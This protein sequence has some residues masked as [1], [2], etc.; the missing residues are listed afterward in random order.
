MQQCPKCG[1]GVPDGRTTCHICFA[2]LG[3]DAQVE[4][5]AGLNFATPQ[6]AAVT[7][8]PAAPAGPLAGAPASIPV[9]PPP[10]RAAGIPGIPNPPQQPAAQSIPGLPGVYAPQEDVSAAQPNYLR[11]DASAMAPPSGM[12]GGQV[13]VSLTG[14]VIESAPA[15]PTISRMTGVSAA[16]PPRPGGPPVPARPTAPARPVRATES[17]ESKSGGSAA[18][19]II[20]IVVFLGAGGFGGWY[21]Y[22]NRTNPKD[23]AIKAMT[24]LK[25]MDWA[26]LHPLMAFSDADKAKYPTPAAFAD[27]QNAKLDKLGIM[28]SLVTSALGG[29]SDITAG[30]PTFEGDKAKVPISFKVNVMGQSIPASQTLPMIKEGGIW[31]FDATA[32]SSGSGGFSLPNMVAGA[33]QGSGLSAGGASSGSSGSSGGHRRGRRSRR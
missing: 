14:E 21:W 15:Q 16:Q 26:A 29:I 1:S 3:P 31:K 11:G 17:Y 19:L 27:A 5:P 33:V 25:N 13:R 24:A 30:E 20:L 10:A 4:G 28:K 23:Q 8:Q 2:E 32:A 12:G 6:S 18:W 22:N 9:P 7:P